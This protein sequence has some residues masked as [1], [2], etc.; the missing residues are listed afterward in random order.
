MTTIEQ[1]NQYPKLMRYCPCLV[2]NKSNGCQDECIRF[3][4]YTNMDDI[5][6]R[7]E[8]FKRFAL[9]M[10]FYNNE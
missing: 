8:R 4:K 2:C 10:G 3:T 5:R 9:K 6:N 7:R 1:E